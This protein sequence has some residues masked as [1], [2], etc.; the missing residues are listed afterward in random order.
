MRAKVLAG[1]SA[2][3]LIA[4]TVLATAGSAS[5]HRWHRGLA[6]GAAGLAAGVVGGAVAAA[7]APLWAPGYYG[8]ADGSYAG[9]G[10]APGYAYAPA[11]T[12]EYTTPGYS[13][14]PLYGYYGAYGESPWYYEGG[15]HPR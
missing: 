4:A 8:Y 10:Y 6:A 3:A 7:T 15:P 12:Y 1:T 14:A 9:Y 11:P 13:S 2:L 5:A